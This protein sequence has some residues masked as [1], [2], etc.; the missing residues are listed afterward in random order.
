MSGTEGK[1]N[2]YVE[3]ANV[4]M[5]ETEHIELNLVGIDVEEI[6]DVPL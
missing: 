5:F 6:S 2:L 4:C 3:R 1:P